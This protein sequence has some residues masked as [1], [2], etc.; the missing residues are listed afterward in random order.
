MDP[1]LDFEMFST[2]LP[3]IPHTQMSTF[4]CTC[5]CVCVCVCIMCLCV[6]KIEDKIKSRCGEGGEGIFS[7]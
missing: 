7:T 2:Q 6:H 3:A 4:G 5:V 1:Y